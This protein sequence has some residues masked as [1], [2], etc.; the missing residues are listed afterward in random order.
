MPKILY[1]MS[2]NW[3]LHQK[4]NSTL[5][6]AISSSEGRSRSKT[7]FIVFPIVDLVRKHKNSKQKLKIEN[8]GF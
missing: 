7:T 2:K 1:Q 3:F 6:G 8:M 5:V 4:N